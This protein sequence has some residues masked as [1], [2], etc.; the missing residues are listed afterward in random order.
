VL[1]FNGLSFFSYDAKTT[2]PYEK[3]MLSGCVCPASEEIAI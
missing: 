3:K 2:A 1:S